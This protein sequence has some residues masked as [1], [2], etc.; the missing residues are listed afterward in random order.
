[1]LLS[2]PYSDCKTA[3]FFVAEWKKTQSILVAGLLFGGC[4]NASAQP[5]SGGIFMKKATGFCVAGLVILVLG[6][7]LFALY[8]CAHRD[9]QRDLQIVY[10]DDYQYIQFTPDSLQEDSIKVYV[11]EFP[12]SY[13]NHATLLV[14]DAYDADKIIYESTDAFSVYAGEEQIRGSKVDVELVT[15]QYEEQIQLIVVSTGKTV[16]E[17]DV[18]TLLAQQGYVTES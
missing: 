8:G 1:V 11:I 6:G 14:D 7:I 9:L 10:T 4:G 13:A 2:E 16:S 18:Y 17:E 5:K 12:G 15:L 3:D